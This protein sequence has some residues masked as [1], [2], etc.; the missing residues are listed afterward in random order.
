MA[1]HVDPRAF[2]YLEGMTSFTNFFGGFPEYHW[3]HGE[4]SRAWFIGAHGVFLAALADLCLQ[5]KEDVVRVFPLGFRNMPWHEGAFQGFRAPGGILV[6][7]EWSKSG[8]VRASVRN[9]S[10][11]AQEFAFQA[12]ASG[13]ARMRLAPGGA[14]SWSGK[15][16]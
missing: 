5:R 7:A 12:G 2:Q 1:V 16:Q 3:L 8:R 6:D 15:A 10:P 4:P 11:T 13:G 9:D 14:A